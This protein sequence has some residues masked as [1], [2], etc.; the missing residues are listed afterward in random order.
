MRK[1]DC[2]GQT[3]L[4]SD[5][6]T[7]VVRV[8]RQLL[9]AVGS[10]QEVVLD[11][12]AAAAL[13]VRA[14]LDRKHHPLFDGAAGGLMR[15]WRLVCARADAVC[16]RMG[17]LLE[18]RVDDAGPDQAVELGEAGAG[19]AV[20]DRAFVHAEQRVEQLVVARLERPRADVLRVVAPVAVR[21]DPDLEQR[22]F[23]LLH[24]TVPCGREGPDTGARPDERKTEGELDL[25]LPPRSFAVHEPLPER[26]SL[27]LLHP[28]A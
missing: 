6:S 18:T 27:A 21:A 15:V 8:A 23:V 1:P 26:R 25:P 20:V 17:W 22:R 11:P 10:D 4:G 28:G 7:E 2:W 19:A 3:P 9:R 24:R 16:D 5:P 14:G 12:Q 13:P